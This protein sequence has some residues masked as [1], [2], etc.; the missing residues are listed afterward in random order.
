MNDL[1]VDPLQE[2]EFFYLFD[3]QTQNNSSL[4]LVETM[5]DLSV[6]ASGTDTM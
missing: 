1:V 5:L 3:V 6:N 4:N 2:D